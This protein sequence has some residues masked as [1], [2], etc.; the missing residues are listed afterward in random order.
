M[1]I[2]DLE[3][4]STKAVINLCDGKNLGYVR[5]IRF[6]SDEGKIC[7][8]VVPKENGI[9]SFGKG[10]NIIIPWN[11]IECIGEDAILVRISYEECCENDRGKKHKFFG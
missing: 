8:I 6:T 1:K 3:C 2:L 7:S 11:K 4:L 9:F 10:E 5:D